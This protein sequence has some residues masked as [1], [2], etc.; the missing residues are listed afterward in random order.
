MALVVRHAVKGDV[1]VIADFAIRLFAQH[2]A[3]DAG[4]FADI[5]DLKGA[6]IY[7]ASRIDAATSAVLVAE[8]DETLVGFAY[9][10]FEAIDYSML[11]ENAACLHDL[12]IAEEARGSGAGKMLIWASIDAGKG[13]GAEKVVLSVAAKNN[14]AHA[15][16]RHV[17]F[18]D[19][20]IEMTLN[21]AE[22]R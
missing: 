9:L 18:R 21:L 4:R 6:A 12:Y 14:M 11:L 15:F 10:E 13:L 20:M 22:P 5:G 1:M 2:R 3:Y 19:T 8:I 7:Y 17:G 16:F